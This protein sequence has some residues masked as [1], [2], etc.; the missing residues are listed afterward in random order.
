MKQNRDYKELCKRI[1][2]KVNLLVGQKLTTKEFRLKLK[3]V[4]CPY[5]VP[6]ASFIS[7]KYA[8]YGQKYSFDT[9]IYYMDF[10]DDIKHFIE[11]KK[12]GIDEVKKTQPKMDFLEKQ[13]ISD[14]EKLEYITDEAL[15]NE[16]RK[17]GYSGSIFI[18]KEIKL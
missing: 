10:Y 18:K 15:L 13:L 11:V 9:P 14:F 8:V 4:N 5:Y 2:A 17:R 6:I 12:Y 1:S 16:L 3:E 7:K